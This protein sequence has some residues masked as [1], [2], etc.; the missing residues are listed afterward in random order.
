[1]RS[2]LPYRSEGKGLVKSCRKVVNPQLRLR[3][4]MSY[5]PFRLERQY[6][7]KKAVYGMSDA[8]PS[9]ITDDR[10]AKMS[11]ILD[12]GAGTCV[13]ILDRMPQI[14]PRLQGGVQNSGSKH[15]LYA[16]DID[17]SF[18]PGGRHHRG[19][20]KCFNY[21]FLSPLVWPERS[22]VTVSHW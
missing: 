7:L 6:L 13:W 17:D 10:L 16:C 21:T 12:V 11:N 18:F 22:T 14:K 1:M 8:I 19:I 15:N 3:K 9:Y 5:P 4:S 20:R 2:N